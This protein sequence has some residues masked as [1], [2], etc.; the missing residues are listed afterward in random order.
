MGQTLD[1]FNKM[2]YFKYFEKDFCR[3]ADY[4]SVP[5]EEAKKGYY[6]EFRNK[7]RVIPQGFKFEEVEINPS[8]YVPNPVPTFA[9]AGGFI[10]GGR[11]PRTLLEYLTSLDREY[12][13]IIYTKSIGLVKPWVEKSNGRM[14]IRDYIERKKLINILSKMD[15]LVNIENKSPLM[16]P[17]KLIDYYLTGRPVLNVT[18]S[19]TENGQLDQFLNGDYSDRYNFINMDRFRIENICR[20]FLSLIQKSENTNAVLQP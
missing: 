8:N 19:L 16:M 12:K 15:F 17:S 6:P 9:Y 7:I 20:N 10:P 13:F 11:D 18:S 14:E 5:I 1:S 3:K 4:I 2:F